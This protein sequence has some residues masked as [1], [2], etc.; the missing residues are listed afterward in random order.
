MQWIE[1]IKKLMLQLFIF[2]GIYLAPIFE[3]AIVI[4]VFVC[5]DFFTGIWAS[6]KENIDIESYK[7]RKSVAKYVIYVIALI[8]SLMFTEHFGLDILTIV[9]FFIASIEVKSIFENL[10]RITNINFLKAIVE[11]MSDHAEKLKSKASKDKDE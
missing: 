10:Y 7:M 5:I 6:R 2:L 9:A 4:L 1:Y 3:T 11:V 8:T